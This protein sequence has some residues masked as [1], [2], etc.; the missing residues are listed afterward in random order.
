M[1]TLIKYNVFHDLPL[2]CVVFFLIA[3][4]PPPSYPLAQNQA[5]GSG[6]GHMANRHTVST[7]SSSS[8]QRIA[9]QTSGTTRQDATPMDMS[10]GPQQ[11]PQGWLELRFICYSCVSQHRC[12]VNSFFVLQASSIAAQNL[13]HCSTCKICI[14]PVFTSCV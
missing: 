1:Q 3:D 11:T 2:A 12:Q 7:A 9:G 6:G 5:N 14:S 10:I 4:S 13:N 8:S